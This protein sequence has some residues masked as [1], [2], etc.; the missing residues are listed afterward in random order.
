MLTKVTAIIRS[1]C[2]SIREGEDEGRKNKREE[3]ERRR[4]IILRAEQSIGKER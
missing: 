3:E 2:F 4:G 1:W